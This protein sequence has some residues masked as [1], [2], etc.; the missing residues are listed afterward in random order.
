MNSILNLYK[1]R[2]ETPLECLERFRHENPEYTNVKM[3]Y[4]GRLDPLAEGIL[5]VLTGT[6]VM[7]KEK[8]L[9]LEKEY[10]VEVLFGAKTDTADLLGVV[11]YVESVKIDIE[12]AKGKL[13]G[14]VGKHSWKYPNFSSK[15]VN[16]VPLFAHT[17]SGNLENIEVPEKEIEIYDLEFLD[18]K[19]VDGREI[20][21]EAK[22]ATNIVK[23]DFRQKECLG[24]WEKNMSDKIGQKFWLAKIS[25]K[26]SSGAYM[27]TF[28][29]KWAESLGTK[30][31]AFNILR[32]KVG[33]FEINL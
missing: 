22:K 20:L 30:G 33:E 17:K 26:V 6:E 12:N 25:A 11:E 23:G 31:I 15:T 13:V 16:G 29:E 8:Y 32:K 28:A 3:T 4:A 14:F 5:V 21:E 9:A 24:S 2:G 1:R 27:R 19:E 7:N 18:L 10:E